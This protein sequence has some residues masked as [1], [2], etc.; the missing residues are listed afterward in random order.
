[1]D[2]GN[3]NCRTTLPT[4]EER[5]HEHDETDEENERVGRTR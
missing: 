1:M 4:R 2:N 3:G 5:E